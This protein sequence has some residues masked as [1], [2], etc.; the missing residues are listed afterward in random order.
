MT[1]TTVQIDPKLWASLSREATRKRI[2]PQNLLAEIV[3]DYLERQEDVRW[4]KSIQR[5]RAGRALSDTEAAEFVR[6]HRRNR[7][8]A[9]K[10]RG[11]SQRSGRKTSD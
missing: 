9:K 8:G 7:A 5:E 3:R 6:A 4:W 2:K 1:P 10:A 11:A